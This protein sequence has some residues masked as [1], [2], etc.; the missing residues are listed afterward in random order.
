MSSCVSDLVGAGQG[1]R[2]SHF[3][4]SD[5]K[6]R[7]FREELTG[8][9][10]FHVEAP[11]PQL[12]LQGQRLFGERRKYSCQRHEGPLGDTANC[13]LREGCRGSMDSPRVPYWM[14]SQ[15]HQ[16]TSGVRRNKRPGIRS[17]KSCRT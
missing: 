13:L 11:R 17:A 3:F 8:M 16:F 1:L 2:R 12:F 10:R 7:G 15:F 14:H 4:Q 9:C 6:I 5:L